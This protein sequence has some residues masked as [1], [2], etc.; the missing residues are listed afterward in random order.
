MQPYFNQVLEDAKQVFTDDKDIVAFRDNKDKILESCGDFTRQVLKNIETHMELFISAGNLS[1]LQKLYTEIR[2]N[3]PKYPNDFVSSEYYDPKKQITGWGCALG[4]Y[5]PQFIDFLG[6]TSSTS[7]YS[8]MKK[9]E[10]NFQHYKEIARRVCNPSLPSSM[11]EA[12]EKYPA[13]TFWRSYII[14][15]ETTTKKL[16]SIKDLFALTERPF[17]S[18]DVFDN[19]QC[20]RN[21]GFSLG[22]AGRKTCKARFPSPC[23]IAMIIT[24]KPREIRF[25]FAPSIQSNIADMILL[26]SHPAEGYIDMETAER[27]FWRGMKP[28]LQLQEYELVEE[29]ETQKVFFFAKHILP[30]VLSNMV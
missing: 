3:E 30:V 25:Y 17:D 29:D 20:Q 5:S 16:P 8:V 11:T 22:Q 18:W 1:P 27:V 13:H 21:Q 9:L 4:I 12:T 2:K 24:Y 15:L 14:G 10:D 26:C 7:H 19:D 6:L 28:V 23:A